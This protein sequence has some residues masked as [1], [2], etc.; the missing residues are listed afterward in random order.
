MR[1]FKHPGKLISGYHGNIFL[2]APLNNNDL[3]IPGNL[4]H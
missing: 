1:C 2:P 4:I 3:P